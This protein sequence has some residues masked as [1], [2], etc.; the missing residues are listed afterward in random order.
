MYTI[1]PR[2][3]ELSLGPMTQLIPVLP[4]SALAEG[5]HHVVRVA[6]Q[7]VLLCNVEGQYYALQGRCSH[8][9]QSLVS[10]RLCGYEIT[11]PLHGARFDVRSGMC[12][13]APA[14]QPIE[15][16]PVLLEGGK[17]CV[18]L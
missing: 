15:R 17:V 4:I 5:E 12:L 3:S 2:E 13:S 1:L 9:G 8:A 7:E 18:V 14:T 16:F 11:C 6:N 10:A